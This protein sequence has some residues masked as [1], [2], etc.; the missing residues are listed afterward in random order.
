MSISHQYITP[1]IPNYPEAEVDRTLYVG[2]LDE[3][4][5][6][7]L[8]TDLFVQVRFKQQWGDK[9]IYIKFYCSLV[10]WSR[11]AFQLQ[12]K[13]R[14]KRRMHLFVT[15]MHVLFHTQ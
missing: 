1:L 9:H 7:S 12:K 14:K 3:K 4:V 2:N 11:F 6:E 10:P 13:T 5:T 15:N 8:L